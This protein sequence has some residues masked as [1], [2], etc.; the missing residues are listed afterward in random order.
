[1]KC[2]ECGFDIAFSYI[3]PTKAFAIIEGRISRDDAWIGPEYDDPYL[4]FYCSND[5]EHEIDTE[6]IVLWTEDIEEQFYKDVLP[7]L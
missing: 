5:N 7:N 3:T 6:D 2:P 4:E 1:M